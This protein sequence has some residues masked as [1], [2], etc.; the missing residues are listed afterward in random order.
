MV[1]QAAVFFTGGF[2]TS[3]STMSFALYELA[4]NPDM[5]EKLRVEIV[6][7]L[8]KSNGKITYD[9]VSFVT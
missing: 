6:D 7:T 1:A 2:E 4:K 9:M 5:Q 3:S 8:E